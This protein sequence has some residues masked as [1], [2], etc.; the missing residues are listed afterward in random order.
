MLGI[1]KVFGFPWNLTSGSSGS[2]FLAVIFCWMLGFPLCA[3]RSLQISWPSAGPKICQHS[4]LRQ[5][6]ILFFWGH[7]KILDSLKWVLWKV[8]VLEFCPYFCTFIIFHAWKLSTFHE[9]DINKIG[10]L[11][12]VFLRHR[13]FRCATVFNG[14][15]VIE[16]KSCREKG[17]LW[18]IRRNSKCLNFQCVFLLILTVFNLATL[19][20]ADLESMRERSRT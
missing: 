18:G 16:L 6:R 2:P 5:S 15:K 9:A 19:E 14:D 10:L 8:P 4:W 12:I 20:L 1:V 7:Q 13:G 17:V 3:G 11:Y